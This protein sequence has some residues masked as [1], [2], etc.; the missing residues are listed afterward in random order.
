LFTPLSVI[1]DACHWGLGKNVA[2]QVLSPLLTFEACE[3]L[4]NC[5]SSKEI[6]TWM[7]LGKA[8]RT[9]A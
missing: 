9:P 6:D 8:W 1:F 2:E 4:R 7:L 5:L 3:L